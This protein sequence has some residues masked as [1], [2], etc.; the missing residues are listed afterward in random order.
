[1][2]GVEVFLPLVL[3]QLLYLL[4]VYKVDE[5]VP[6]TILRHKANNLLKDLWFYL[7]QLT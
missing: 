5:V 6:P 1:M 3:Y 2:G 4:A 7:I